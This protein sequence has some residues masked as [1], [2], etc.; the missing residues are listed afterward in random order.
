MC[1]QDRHIFCLQITPGIQTSYMSHLV[2]DQT[3]FN[4]CYAFHGMQIENYEIGLI[5]IED[6]IFPK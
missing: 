5:N 2:S 4:G 3:H 6:K 1:P